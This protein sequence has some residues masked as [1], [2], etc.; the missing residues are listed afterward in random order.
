[1][2]ATPGLPVQVRSYP[3][4]ILTSFLKYSHFPGSS[5]VPPE[6]TFLKGPKGE[7]GIKGEKGSGGTRGPFGPQGLFGVPGNAGMILI[8][9]LNYCSPLINAI[10][11]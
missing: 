6:I 7:L 9:S 4:L 2:L 3:Y 10:H 5:V 1:M 8:H 11:R